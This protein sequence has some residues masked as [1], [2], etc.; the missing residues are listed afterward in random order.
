MLSS[1]IDPIGA[2]CYFLSIA[3]HAMSLYV[4]GIAGPAG[5]KEGGPF[6]WAA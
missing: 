4:I 5:V 6:L 1:Q 3:E 2:V